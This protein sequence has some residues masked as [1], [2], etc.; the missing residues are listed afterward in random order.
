[1]CNVTQEQLDDID[2]IYD[3]FNPFCSQ[4]VDPP[5]QDASSEKEEGI[6]SDSGDKRPVAPEVNARSGKDLLESV[7]NIITPKPCSYFLVVAVFVVTAAI[8]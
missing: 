1:M 4:S 7:G 6:S 5:I 3:T 8:S 2:F